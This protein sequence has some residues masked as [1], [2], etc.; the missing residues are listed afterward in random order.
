MSANNS[1][2]QN[3]PSY[4]GAG[5]EPMTYDPET[6]VPDAYPG[7]YAAKVINAKTRLTSKSSKPMIQIEWKLLATDSETDEA[8]TSLQSTISDWIV[9]SSDKSGNRGKIKLRQ[10]KEKLGLDADII[11][12]QIASFD[13]F[14][15]FIE[16][17]KGAELTVYVTNNTDPDG[18]V[19]VNVDYEPRGGQGMAP[20]TMATDA[21]EEEAPPAKPAAK[22]KTS[23]KPAAPAKGG[24]A[25]R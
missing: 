4:G 21:E 22:A 16:A 17:I 24:K 5:F 18:N 10:L 7:I 19:R 3:T 11:P 15:A 14:A 8:Q 23:A 6:I 2:S 13:D 12:V 20:M 25:K 1:V 9:I